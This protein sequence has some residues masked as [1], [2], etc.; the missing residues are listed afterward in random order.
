[1]IASRDAR[2]IVRHYVLAEIDRAAD[3]ALLDVQVE[4]GEAEL[5]AIPCYDLAE[6]LRC[7][8]TRAELPA[9]ALDDLSEIR[10]GVERLEA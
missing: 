3:L 7:P 9:A 8:W 4:V 6:G 2:E 1:M 10:P 5:W